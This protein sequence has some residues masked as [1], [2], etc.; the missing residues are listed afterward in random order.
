MK[1]IMLYAYG[2]FN[3]GDDLFIKVIL[4]RYP[5]TNF[6]FYA[7]EKY[8]ETLKDYKNIKVINK[9]NWI[10]NK[11]KKIIPNINDRILNE[12]EKSCDGMIYIGGSIFIQYPDWKNYINWY[13]NKINK[14]PVFIIGANFGPFTE[15][16]FVNG[17]REIYKDFKDICFR[18]KFSY[19][20]FKECDNVR[21]A[22]DIIFSL[23]IDEVKKRKKQIFISLIDCESRNKTNVPIDIL[24][25]YSNEYFMKMKEIIDN[26]I[27]EGYEII[28]SPFCINENDLIITEKIYNSFNYEKKK[29]IEIMSYDG[30]NINQI[31]GKIAESEY[32][33]GTRFHAIILGFVSKTPVFP[34]I[35]SNKTE[36][37][38]KD[39]EFKG[40]YCRIS[41][42][43]N[44]DYEYIKYNLNNKI[45]L[46]IE[47][48]K[49]LSEKHFKELD[50]FLIEDKSEDIK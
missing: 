29:K 22:P 21:I 17:F 38:L 19:D 5:H 35:Y 47:K 45:I 37:M 12:V 42:M 4:E 48:L 3:L 46:D 44:I 43:K 16:G 1:K 50:K 9:D 34:I 25:L 20:L 49:I 10:I 7:H 8:K 15:I 36:N 33:I 24:D 14:F 26:F 39:I 27:D 2:E 6:I 32:I 18:D 31:I 30:F 40:Q 23:N 11:V 41:D 13:K 28:L